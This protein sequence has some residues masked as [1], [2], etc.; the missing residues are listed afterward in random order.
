M[1]NNIFKQAITLS[2]SAAAIATFGASVVKNDIKSENQQNDYYQKIQQDN[3]SFKSTFD[4]NPYN[5]Q[6]T[7]NQTKVFDKVNKINTDVSKKFYFL[8]S[9]Y[10]NNNYSKNKQL[11]EESLNKAIEFIYFIEEEKIKFDNVLT[12]E[13]SGFDFFKKNNDGSITLIS[14]QQNQTGLIKFDNKMNP[15]HIESGND[16]T[17]FFK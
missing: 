1:K 9:N 6:L 5:N 14:L 10:M 12:N 3:L 7:E 2:L 17:S 11:S 15:V 8:V 4:N 16:F 13:D